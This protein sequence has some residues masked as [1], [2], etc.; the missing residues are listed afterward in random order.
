M[1]IA[2]SN[3]MCGILYQ[4]TKVTRKSFPVT[5][6]S[7]ILEK[8][9]RI[10]P[11]DE[12]FLCDHSFETQFREFLRITSPEIPEKF[13]VL[14]HQVYGLLGEFPRN[15]L[16]EVPRTHSSEWVTRNSSE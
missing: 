6:S 5:D 9:P 8:F 10:G 1:Y 16:H 12:G 3:T 15:G 2:R 4:V 11:Q 7:E 13:L 14:G